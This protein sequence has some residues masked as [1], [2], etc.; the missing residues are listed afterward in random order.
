M[1]N[2]SAAAWVVGQVPNDKPEESN[3]TQ[4]GDPVSLKV[5]SSDT[6]PTEQDRGAMGTDK[7]K[8]SGKPK[9]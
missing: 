8:Q 4:L 5:E 6:E 3:P 9:L 2:K 1:P 7:S